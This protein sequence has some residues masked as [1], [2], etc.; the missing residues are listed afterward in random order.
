MWP[1][2]THFCEGLSSQ[3]NLHSSRYRILL[4]FTRWFRINSDYNNKHNK[5]Q[6]FRFDIP[7]VRRASNLSKHN[8]I[9]QCVLITQSRPTIP[10]VRWI[11]WLCRTWSCSDTDPSARDTWA[12]CR[13]CPAR[14]TQNHWRHWWPWPARSHQ[15]VGISTPPAM[16]KP[17]ACTC[18]SIVNVL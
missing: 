7:H 18:K 15:S 9:T 3:M 10:F 6:R 11:E 12:A 4:I 1:K 16:I 5:Y 13:W 8:D 17:L 2:F 14:N